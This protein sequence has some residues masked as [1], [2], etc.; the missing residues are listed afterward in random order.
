MK[1][2]I[3]KNVFETNS[4]ST[5]S[6]VFS[7]NGL[8]PSEFILNKDNELTITYGN[9][10]SWESYGEYNDQFTKLSYLITLCWYCFPKGDVI[11]DEI[12]FKNIEKAVCKY[13]G[14]SRIIVSDEIEPDL[15]HQLIPDYNE[16]DLLNTWNEDEV[17]NFIFNK[18]VL[19]VL[20][21]D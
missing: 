6:I 4:S 5:H 3:R 13:T 21:R 9:F 10:D 17:I 15:N 19:L 1:T 8:E 7:K 18:N 11:Y 14:A 20:D 2:K 16:F 12:N